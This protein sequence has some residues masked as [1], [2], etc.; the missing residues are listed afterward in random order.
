MSYFAYVCCYSYLNPQVIFYDVHDRH[1]EDR[2]LD[3]LRKHNIQSVIIKAG[4]SVHY[5]PNHNNPNMKLKNFYAN[6]IMNWKIYHKTL[7]FTPAHMNS[8]LVSTWEDFK[9]SSAKITQNNFKKKNILPLIPPYIDTNHQACLAGN[10]QLKAGDSVHYHPN[11]KNPNMKLN[12]LYA[13]AIMNW[14]IHHKTLKFTP[15]HMNSTLV[16]TW[17]DFTLSSAKITQNNFKKKNILPLL[18]PYIDTNHQ[19]CLACN[20]QSN[21]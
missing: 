1:F 19:D 14:K 12:N 6:A 21:R 7:K 13:N 10:Q 18:P 2:A 4:D 9:L 11:N 20:Q 15:A 8:T 3:I 5:H 16:S 17:E